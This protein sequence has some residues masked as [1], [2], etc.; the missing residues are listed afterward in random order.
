MSLLFYRRPDFIPRMSGPMDVAS[1]Q[2]IVSRQ[3]PNKK[4]IPDS[5]AFDRIIEERTLPPCSL[6]DFMDYLVYVTF[7]AENLQ[8]FM[9]YRDYVKRF[10]E[11]GA[12]A[13]LLSPPVE[14]LVGQGS[15]SKSISDKS[16]YAMG[17]NSTK[18]SNGKSSE[19]PIPQT[20]KHTWTSVGV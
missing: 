6:S 7:D 13:Q 20:C 10:N 18:S 4:F 3:M 2:R 12:E 15:D 5:V 14:V 1:C 17:S 16:I 11:L 9:W 8:F 19:F